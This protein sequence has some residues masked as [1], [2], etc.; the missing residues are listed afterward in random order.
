ME[1]ET[2]ERIKKEGRIIRVVLKN[3]YSYEGL[4]DDISLPNKK[5][6]IL[7]SLIDRKGKVSFFNTEISALLESNSNIF[8]KINGDAIWKN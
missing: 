8:P 4:F 1:R 6:I 5:G 2:L 7:C 3:G